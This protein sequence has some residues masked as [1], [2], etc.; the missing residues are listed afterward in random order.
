[1]VS[2]IPNR[3]SSGGHLRFIVCH[4]QSCAFSPSFSLSN[5]YTVSVDIQTYQYYQFVRYLLL[6]SILFR[7]SRFDRH[8]YDSNVKI[9]TTFV[10]VIY[11][12]VKPNLL[13]SVLATECQLHRY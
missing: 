5:V 12:G 1:M 4:A 2:M 10:A 3:Q 9:T 13:D 7:H 8:V 11:L 6:F